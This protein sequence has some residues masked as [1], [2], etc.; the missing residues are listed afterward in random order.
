MYITSFFDFLAG[1]NPGK[2]V[3]LGDDETVAIKKIDDDHENPYYVKGTELQD[4]QINNNESY[5]DCRV[6]LRA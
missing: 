5:N 4:A 6:L 1:V 2:V 3:P